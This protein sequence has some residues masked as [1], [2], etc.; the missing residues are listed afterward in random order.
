M[1]T[2]FFTSNK[3][4]GARESKIQNYDNVLMESWVRPGEGDNLD[5]GA[6]RA[7]RKSLPSLS[8]LHDSWYAVEKRHWIVGE[9]ESCKYRNFQDQMTYAMN[10]M[11]H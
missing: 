11:I 1:V 3:F 7:A 5:K 2:F 10:A 8:M 9:R 4:R 6:M